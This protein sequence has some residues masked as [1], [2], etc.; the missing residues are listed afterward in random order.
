MM[1]DTPP[2]P[3]DFELFESPP[4]TVQDLPVELSHIRKEIDRSR[5]LFSGASQIAVEEGEASYTAE[6][7]ERAVRFLARSAWWAFVRLRCV[8]DSPR[9]LPGPDGSVDLHWDEPQYELLVNIP[10]EQGA[11]A[12][13]YGDD[14][15]SLTIKGKVHPNSM[16]SGLVLFLT[17]SR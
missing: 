15:K 8:I 4:E 14:R 12:G 9:V 10:A 7:W 5:E 1:E 13:F 11:W 16:N 2:R 3:L 17:E 6:V